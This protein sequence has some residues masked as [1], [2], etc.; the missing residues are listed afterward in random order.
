M[1]EMT[2]VRCPFAKC[3]FQGTQDE[4]D[5]HVILVTRWS[6]PEHEYAKYDGS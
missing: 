6:D 4:V 2:K 5:Q 1:S 3:P